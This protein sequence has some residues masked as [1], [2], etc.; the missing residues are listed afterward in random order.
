M[1]GQVM[2]AF[3]QKTTVKTSQVGSLALLGELLNAPISLLLTRAETHCCIQPAV[4]SSV[5]IRYNYC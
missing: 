2:G 5:A 3:L 4:I 1:A